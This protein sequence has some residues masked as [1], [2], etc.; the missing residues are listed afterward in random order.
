M[1]YCKFYCP[2]QIVIMILYGTALFNFYRG[3]LLLEVNHMSFLKTMVHI[4]LKEKPKRGKLTKVWV[5][6]CFS[7]CC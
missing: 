6:N 7:I 4:G 2:N 5:T 3:L 1:L